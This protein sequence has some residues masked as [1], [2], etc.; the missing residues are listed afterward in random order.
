MARGPIPQVADGQLTPCD[1]TGR[2]LSPIAVGSA[3]WYAWLTDEATRSFAFHAE[4]WF[5]RANLFITP[6]YEERRW[7]R[8]HHL[9][10]DLLRYRL[11][12]A[13]AGLPPELHRRAAAWYEEQGLSVFLRPGYRCVDTPPSFTF[14]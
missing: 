9:F 11:Q 6:L 14:R 12:Q 8:Y 7:Y 4:Q 3:G 10:A 13:Q 5:E 2:W 1:A